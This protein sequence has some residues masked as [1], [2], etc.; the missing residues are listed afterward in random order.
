MMHSMHRFSAVQ[1]AS[2]A[3]IKRH[4]DLIRPGRD[5]IELIARHAPD[6]PGRRLPDFTS[7]IEAV[8]LVNW[9]ALGLASQPLN[10]ARRVDE[11][12]LGNPRNGAE[13]EGA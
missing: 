12:I 9:A 10:P 8:I 13:T 2:R 4:A 7:G 1:A 6:R 5:G 11:T 3:G